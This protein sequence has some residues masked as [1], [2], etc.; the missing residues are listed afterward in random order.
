MT[1]LPSTNIVLEEE[2]DKK[3]EPSEEGNQILKQ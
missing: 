1:M 3:F 2:I